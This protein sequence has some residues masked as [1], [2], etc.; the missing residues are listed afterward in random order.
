MGCILDVGW[1][2]TT[3]SAAK[4][5]VYIFASQTSTDITTTYGIY[6]LSFLVK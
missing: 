5:P 3:I 6:D 2:K 1:E 4:G